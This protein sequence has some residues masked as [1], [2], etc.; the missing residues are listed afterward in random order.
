[1][2]KV[3]PKD[4]VDTLIIHLSVKGYSFRQIQE[5]FMDIKDF[6]YPSLGYISKVL[7]QNGKHQKK[8]G[9]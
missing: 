2:P 7:N 6:T 4:I 1:M 8:K 3:F 9:R 5:I